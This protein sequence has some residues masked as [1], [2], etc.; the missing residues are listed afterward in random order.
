MN[1][2]FIEQVLDRIKTELPEILKT[3]LYNEDYAK[4]DQGTKSGLN[5]PAAFLSFPEEVQYRDT[6]SGVQETYD[7][8][9]R[10]L[11][12]VK[13]VNE[14][15]VF[16]AFDLKD[17]FF[18]TFHNWQPQGSSSFTRVSEFTDEDRPGYYIFTQDYRTRL[19]DTAKFIENDRVEASVD[20]LQVDGELIID[21]R[22]TEGVR[23]DDRTK[24]SR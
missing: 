13:V 8:T 19:L 2:Q 3:G 6:S 24:V 11:I 20:T 16:R 22:T 4:A 17:K 21:P 12:G 10:F 7:F 14:D 15:A 5:F 1:R 9:V 23:T 18:K